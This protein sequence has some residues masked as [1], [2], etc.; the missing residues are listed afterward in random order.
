MQNP[1]ELSIPTTVA[2]VGRLNNSLPLFP[3]G[4]ESDNIFTPGEILKILEWSIP[5]V[6]RT[7]FDSDGFIPTEFTKERF[8]TECKA[9]EQKELKISIKSKMLP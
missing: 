4:K 7:K 8:M 9:V 5:E 3:N 1:K 6:W 2:A